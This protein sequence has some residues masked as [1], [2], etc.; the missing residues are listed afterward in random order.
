MFPKPYTGHEKET[1]A[2]R[3]GK[4]CKNV[5]PTCKF[6]QS[7][8]VTDNSTGAVKEIWECALLFQ[9]QLTIE[10]NIF[11]QGVQRSIESFRNET[12]REHQSL[13]HGTVKLAERM[14]ERVPHEHTSE[15]VAPPRT[16]TAIGARPECAN[17]QSGAQ[18]GS[19]DGDS[20]GDRHSDRG[21]D[22]GRLVGPAS[23]TDGY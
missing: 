7:F 22:R 18:M 8:T 20:R 3:G 5:C 10:N 14:L 21:H 6:Q 9:T 1:C 16:A 11:T 19:S 17:G 23:E 12:V 4:L 15:L 13:V 2:Y